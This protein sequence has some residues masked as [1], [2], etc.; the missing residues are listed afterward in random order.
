MIASELDRTLRALM[1]NRTQAAICLGVNLTTLR[2]WLAGT[3]TIPVAVELLLDAWL[4][5]PHLI[6]V[7]ST[8]IEGNHHD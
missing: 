5:Y 8:R 4:L 2:R 1:L 3:S 7:T 6:P